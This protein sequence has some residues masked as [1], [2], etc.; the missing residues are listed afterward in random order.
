MVYNMYIL[1]SLYITMIFSSDIDD[2]DP[3]PCQYGGA[4]S[5]GLDSFTCTCADGYHGETCQHGRS[6]N[7]IS[8][9]YIIRLIVS[10]E[11]TN[12]VTCYFEETDECASNPCFPESTCQ[13]YV[14]YYECECSPGYEGILC[15][16]GKHCLTIKASIIYMQ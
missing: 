13:D 5:D 15:G 10:I 16:D 4:C 3:N 12:F 9:F 14:N 1:Y 7:F 11:C 8:N 2:C 6:E